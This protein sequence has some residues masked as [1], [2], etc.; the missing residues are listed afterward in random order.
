LEQLWFEVI[1]NVLFNNF[2]EIIDLDNPLVAI[3]GK[4]NVI[5]DE[6]KEA[7]FKLFPTGSH[8]NPRTPEIKTPIE[9]TG[10]DKEIVSDQE[11]ESGQQAGGEKA[12]DRQGSDSG[13]D[14]ETGSEKEAAGQQENSEE[15]DE[16]SDVEDPKATKGLVLSQRGKSAIVK[17]NAVK[18]GQNVAIADIVGGVVIRRSARS[19]AVKSGQ[20]VKEN[21]NDFNRE[22]RER[23]RGKGRG[24]GR[25]QRV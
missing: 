7:W 15:T 17:A 19:T 13:S 9:E 10:R 5:G 16:G 3:V 20:N 1:N 11:T 4:K 18:R 21:T 25:V 12:I 22:G 8:I 6:L 14:Q 24:R 2:K 23:G